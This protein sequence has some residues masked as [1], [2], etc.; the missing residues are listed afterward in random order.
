MKKKENKPPEIPRWL[1]SCLTTAEE[2][3]SI[4]A[5]FSEIYE[6]RM[7]AA[8]RFKAACWYWSQVIKS[9]PM[10][11]KNRLFWSMSMFKN[12]L[13][14]ALMNI[15]KHKG[16]SL[17]N[18]AGLATGMACCILILI[19][20]KEDLSYDRFH[21]HT[22][23]LYRVVN[24]LDFGPTRFDTYGT[25]YPLG[26]AMKKEI[27]EILDTA[28]FLP[29][30]KILVSTAENRF[31][32][33]KFYFTDP[34]VFKMF[35]FPFIKGDAGSALSNPSSVVITEE[36]AFKYFGNRDPLGQTIQAK[37]QHDYT[38][39]GVIK[40]IP[41]NSH[42]QFD[43]LASVERAASL[44][45]K[46][47]WTAWFYDTYVLLKPGSSF[48]EVNKKLA[49]WIKKHTDPCARY[50]L[51]P[52]AEVYLYGL[53]G[54]GAVNSLYLF[55]FLAVLILLVACIN[56]MNL[57]TARSAGR[58]KEIGL[59]KVVG[60][61]KKNIV[62]QFLV[63]SVLFASF[64]LVLSLI[65]VDIFLPVFN[66]LSGKNL[67]MGVVFSDAILPGLIG[68]VLITGFL[69]GCY[70]ALFLS[71]FKPGVI[72]KG[73]LRAGSKSAA[74]RKV[75]IVFQF[76]LAIVL[77]IGTIVVYNQL[78]YISNRKMG[79][80]KDHLIYIQLRGEG[81]LWD[82]Y[83]V[84]KREFLQTPDVINVAGSTCLPFQR[85]AA[86]FGQLDWQGKNPKDNIMMNHM[87]VDHSFLDTFKM[88]MVEGRFFSG[89]KVSDKSGFILNEAAV[90]A[91]GLD[92]PVGEKFRL[93][94]RSGRII[95]VVKD[96]HFDS[97][98][99]EIAPL[100]LMKMPYSYWDYRNY[101]FVR[102]NSRNMQ[103]TLQAL[104]KK[105]HKLVPAYPFVFN[106]LD[107]TIDNLYRSEKK[108]AKI[109]RSF[110]LIALLISCLGLFGLASYMVENRTREIGVRKVLGAP[111]SG[112]V[113]S[114][115]KEFT[116]LVLLANIIA[117]PTA[118]FVMSKWLQNFAYHLPIRIETF[119]ISGSLAFLL[120]LFTVG[121]Q[122]IKAA[123]ANPV[124]SL[125][126]E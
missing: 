2:R 101:I 22:R 74:F 20:I 118:Y 45:Y 53:N 122:S 87:A 15:K 56:Y 21:E 12:Y 108:L 14:I 1:L 31:Y 85:V 116:K 64:A 40:N 13:K 42:L 126:Y 94:D 109:L 30:K 111:V 62:K 41:E 75:L 89:E 124:D 19:W 83:N 49:P 54:S 84:I 66:E 33:E 5:D 73:T 68:I 123:V 32:E 43:F 100:I 82:K 102:I 23:N 93:L 11:C 112:I 27:P 28:R 96:F 86:E 39:T 90:K 6:E 91:A 117:W 121:Y 115:S 18:I 67:H 95:G 60:A 38:V 120:A 36:I 79:F 4:T 106:F 76:T 17:I 55:S 110:T 104:E 7:A 113:V 26:P 71:S 114:F 98:R 35:T 65:L 97:L 29:A 51:Q 44:G 92:S 61:A 77:I 8:G 24:D 52:L 125:R 57:A 107:A 37:N 69:S 3:R 48:K 46:T 70:P 81:E 16:Y 47:H 72:L 78:D 59:R 50:Y 119:I 105:W 99:S 34:A 9:M 80:E 10:F 25:P 58:A 88:E 63:E 103:N